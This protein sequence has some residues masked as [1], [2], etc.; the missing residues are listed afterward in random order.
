ATLIR[1]GQPDAL[2]SLGR[3]ETR[4]CLAEELRRLDPDE[5]YEEALAGLEK[6][7]YE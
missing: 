4:D 6:V 3:R 2:V 7:T 5:N 1:T